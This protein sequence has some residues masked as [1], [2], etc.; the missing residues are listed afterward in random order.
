MTLISILGITAAFF[1][2]G[3]YLPQAYKTIKSK[4]TGDL[5]VVTFAMVWTGTVL[6][7]IYGIFLKDLP[8]ILANSITSMLTGFILFLKIQS[9]LKAKK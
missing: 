2:T 3:A 5:S 9:M 6:W 7:L 4:S 8:L 1:T